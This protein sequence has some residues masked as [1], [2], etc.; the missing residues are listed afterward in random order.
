MSRLLVDADA[1]RA[2]AEILTETGLTEIEIA[3]KDSR[4]RVVR[5]APAATHAVAPP[6]P[7]AAPAPVAAPVPVAAPPAD[8]SKHP[9]AVTSPMV[10]VAYLTPDPSAPPFVTE[11][12]QVV[13]GQTLMLIEAMK[14]FNQIKAPRAGTLTKILVPSGEPVEYG[15]VLAI[16]E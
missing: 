6:P 1:I 12:Q 15:E 14:T 11:G 5:A 8:L 10:G 3:E 16:I 13:A 7:V 4:V 2:L 9:G